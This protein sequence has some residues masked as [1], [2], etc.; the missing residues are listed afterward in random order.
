MKSSISLSG[1]LKVDLSVYRGDSGRFRITVTDIAGNPVDVSAATWDADIR[2]KAD[3]ADTIGNFV[4]VPDATD[5]SSIDV[6]LPAD[7]SGTLPQN[8]TYDVEMRMGTDVKTLVCGNITVTQD[9]S[10]P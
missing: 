8:C 10:R 4:I 7:L 1:P 6:E 5:T 2:L 3:D 9:V